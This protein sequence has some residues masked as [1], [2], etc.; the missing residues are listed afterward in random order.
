VNKYLKIARIKGNA[1]IAHRA[2][3]RAV[4]GIK[5]GKLIAFENAVEAAKILKAKG[6]KINASNIRL[7]CYEKLQ[8]NN[9]NGKYYIRKSAGGYQWFFAEQI[10]KYR[11]LI[12][13]NS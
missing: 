1:E 10:E 13:E 3:F 2:R 4:V 9:R 11:E 7:V 12:Y 8:K 6:I 5:D